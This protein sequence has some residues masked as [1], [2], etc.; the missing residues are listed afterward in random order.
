M[1][2]FNIHVE[3]DSQKIYFDSILDSIGFSQSTHRPTCSLN[4]TLDLVLTY[5]IENE[6][7]SYFPDYKLLQCI[8]RISQKIRHEEEKTYIRHIY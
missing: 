8:S 2:D 7:L 6:Q 3:N 4:H 5:G 1:G